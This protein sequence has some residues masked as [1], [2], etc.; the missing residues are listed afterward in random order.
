MPLLNSSITST[1]ISPK[2]SLI[3][4]PVFL[5]GMPASGKTTIGKQVAIELDLPFLDTDHWLV[6]RYGM[7][8]SEIFSH[9]GDVHFRNSEAGFLR[10]MD[11]TRPKVVATGGGLPCYH[12]NMEWMLKWGLV[13]HIHTPIDELA[14]RIVKVPERPMF[15]GLQP[16]AIVKKLHEIY[17]QRMSVYESAH[18]TW[19]GVDANPDCSS[20]SLLRTQTPSKS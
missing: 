5:V 16:S 11:L 9:Y 8:I 10:T 1:N 17:N 19:T 7:S 3:D 6:E 13:V 14:R 20:I 4:A 12:D 18:L 2:K 15:M